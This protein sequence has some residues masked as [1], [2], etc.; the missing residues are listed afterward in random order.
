M[1]MIRFLI[2]INQSI[3]LYKTTTC[4]HHP[5]YYHQVLLGVSSLLLLSSLS[6]SSSLL[7]GWYSTF[8][9]EQLTQAYIKLFGPENRQLACSSVCTLSNQPGT[10]SPIHGGR[11]SPGMYHH[12]YYHHYYCFHYYH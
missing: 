2:S 12:H 1:I 8:R 4:Y 9:G 3:I 10:Q 6:S 11:Q 7:S 5:L